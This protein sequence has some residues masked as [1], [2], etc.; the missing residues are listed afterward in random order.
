[1]LRANAKLAMRLQ[2][3]NLLYS[4]FNHPNNLYHLAR[5]C[6]WQSAVWLAR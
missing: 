6:A 4:V 5:G 3:I 1:M 2:A